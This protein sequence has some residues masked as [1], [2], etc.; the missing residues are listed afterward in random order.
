MNV[1]II[2]GGGLGSRFG[3][4]T[5]KQFIVINTRAILIETLE[6]FNTC[7][8][9]DK[10]LIVMHEKYIQKTHKLISNFTLNKDFEIII[11]GRT[12]QESSYK[13]LSHI[14]ENPPSIVVIHDAVRPLVTRKIIT[15]SIRAAEKYGAVDVVVKATDT[16]VY[17]KNGFIVN[18]PD[19][20]CYYY[21]QT[22]QS[23]K[24]D[25][26]WKAHQLAKKD[27]FTNATDDAKLVLRLDKKVR[28]VQGNYSNIKLTNSQDFQ[29][30]K[31]LFN[32]KK[33]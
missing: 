14:N 27:D 18:I 3:R 17:A 26:I 22:P 13:A 2:L 29:F 15:D 11:G 30:I 25:I 10:I 23:F 20:E 12:R 28:I 6:I 19:R 7:S 33:D 1:A 8:D 5:P 21:G 24:Y 32:K 16:I 4:N 9:I 31:T